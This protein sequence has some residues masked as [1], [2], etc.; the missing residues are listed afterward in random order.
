MDEKKEDNIQE[1][2]ELIYNCK[3]GKYRLQLLSIATDIKNSKYILKMV[4]PDCGFF[5]SIILS[6]DSPLQNVNNSNN[7]NS[8]AQKKSY[9]Y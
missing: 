4:C 2:N 3:C 6:I 7:T 1:I 8:E 9:I 5:Q